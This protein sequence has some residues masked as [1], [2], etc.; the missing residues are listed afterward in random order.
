MLTRAP[1][2]ASRAIALIG[3]FSA[4]Y[5]VT[6]G[7]ASFLSQLGYPEHF[8]RGILMSAAVLWTGKKWS[9]TIMGLVS[10]LIFLL[11]VPSPAPYLLPSTFISGLVFDAIILVGGSYEVASRSRLR[12]ILAAAIS[13]LAESIVALSILTVFSAP[14]LGRTFG[15]IAAAWSFD[16]ALNIILS[17]IGAYLVFRFLI[18]RIVRY[19][20]GAAGA[21]PAT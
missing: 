17:S 11:L 13:G 20:D 4:L 12:L 18:K 3:L 7:I 14:T 19:S 15:A 5:I 6:S 10:G 8:L 16:I 2:S 1:V 21:R 9:A